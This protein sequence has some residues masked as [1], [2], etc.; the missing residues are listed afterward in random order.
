MKRGRPPTLRILFETFSTFFTFSATHI[1]WGDVGIILVVAYN[2][3]D[4]SSQE[5]IFERSTC[6]YQVK[7]GPVI[8]FGKICTRTFWSSEYWVLLSHRDGSG[9]KDKCC[10][11]TIE[12]LA[13]EIL[14]ATSSSGKYGY[15]RKST[16]PMAFDP[17]YLA[18]LLSKVSNFSFLHLFSAFLLASPS[19]RLELADG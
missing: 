5:F 11:P 8:L 12:N 2:S 7:V 18:I 9:Q 3:M 13:I 17:L 19:S 10:Y 1:S 4:K 15:L 14:V 6:V 16:L